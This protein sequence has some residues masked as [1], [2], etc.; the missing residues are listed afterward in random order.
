M[1]SQQNCLYKIEKLNY[2]P[3]S[4]NSLLSMLMNINCRNHDLSGLMGLKGQVFFL[5]LIFSS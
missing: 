5:P 4:K 3:H 2:L 1:T